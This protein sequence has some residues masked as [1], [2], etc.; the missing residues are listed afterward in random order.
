MFLIFNNI[1]KERR[2]HVTQQTLRLINTTLSNDIIERADRVST[3]VLH[4]EVPLSKTSQKRCWSC[5]LFQAIRSVVT[6]W[7][8]TWYVK[9]F[10]W[11]KM[12]EVLHNAA[13]LPPICLRC[14]YSNTAIF[15]LLQYPLYPFVS[16][17]RHIISWA[18]TES[19]QWSVKKH[20][21]V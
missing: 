1:Q 12:T 9:Y 15:T 17:N 21:I 10:W 3:P 14:S 4:M 8:Q 6:E 18:V 16:Q 20:V 19:L 13:Y 5:I 7:I 11:S 2:H